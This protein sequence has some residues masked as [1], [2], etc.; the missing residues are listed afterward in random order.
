ML[1]RSLQQRMLELWGFFEK[2]SLCNYDCFYLFLLHLTTLSV[3][4]ITYRRKMII[5]G[6]NCLEKNVE[7]I[8]CQICGTRPGICIKGLKKTTKHH[9]QDSQHPHRTANY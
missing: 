5:I 7:I 4:Q 3:A 9:N 6:N 8:R 1:C 2:V